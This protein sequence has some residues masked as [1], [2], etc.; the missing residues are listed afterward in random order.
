MKL[1]FTVDIKNLW[2]SN[3]MNYIQCKNILTYPETGRVESPW[4]LDP[5]INHPWFTPSLDKLLLNNS[6]NNSFYYRCSSSTN[7]PFLSSAFLA[8]SMTGGR[9]DTNPP[10]EDNIMVELWKWN[11]AHSCISL[12][13]IPVPNLVVKAS[14]P[15]CIYDVIIVYFT[16]IYQRP[17]I[18]L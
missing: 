10:L 13:T 3:F 14:N 18:C 8:F 12:K 16:T 11:L 1:P 4:T 6:L 5:S 2:G 9:E 17:C 15:W 7:W